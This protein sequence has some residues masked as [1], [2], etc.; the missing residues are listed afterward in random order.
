MGR[1]GGLS[2]AL[3]AFACARGV[4]VGNWRTL[5]ILGREVVLSTTEAG[6]TRTYVLDEA[7]LV[8]RLLVVVAVDSSLVEI[9]GLERKREGT[10]SSLATFWHMLDV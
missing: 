4:A 6:G 5:W 9:Q 10:I 7:C 3:V 2:G 8:W 1:A